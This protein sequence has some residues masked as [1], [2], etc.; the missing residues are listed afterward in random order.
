MVECSENYGLSCIL[1]FAL[2]VDKVCTYYK[3]HDYEQEKQAPLRVGIICRID[4]YVIFI[5]NSVQGH[6]QSDYAAE[7]AAEGNGLVGISV[8]AYSRCVVHYGAY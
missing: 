8:N 4:G 5:K 2:A 3:K 1:C 7:G 6:Y